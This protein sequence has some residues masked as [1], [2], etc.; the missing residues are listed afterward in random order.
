[1][2]EPKAKTL[3]DRKKEVRQQ[4]NDVG[5]VADIISGRKT[6]QAKTV[7]GKKQ[8]V[9]KSKFDNL[10]ENINEGWKGLGLGTKKLYGTE[11]KK[12]VRVR[13]RK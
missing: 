10:I 1:M 6:I 2:A 13:V 9:V 3:E 8:L 7:N 5:E 4:I 12:F 11:P